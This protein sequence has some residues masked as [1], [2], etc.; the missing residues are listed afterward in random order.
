VGQ[1]RP[2]HPYPLP[3]DGAGDADSKRSWCRLTYT[4]TRHPPRPTRVRGVGHDNLTVML[5]S[6]R[7]PKL[8]RAV[9]K[10]PQGGPTHVVLDGTLI[11]TDRAKA[12]RP[13]FSGK[14][15]VHGMN[16]QATVMKSRATAAQ[17]PS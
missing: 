14:R 9:R 2:R 5:L 1:R 13:Y 7:S 8:A 17:R 6:A 16:V 3:T 10:A 11:P 4:K 12:R 15:R